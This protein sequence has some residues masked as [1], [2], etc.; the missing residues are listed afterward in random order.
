[1]T[2]YSKYTIKVHVYGFTFLESTAKEKLKGGI[3]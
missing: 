1:M 2:K 3:G